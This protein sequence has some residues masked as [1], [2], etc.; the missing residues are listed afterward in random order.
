L[1]FG[2]HDVHIGLQGPDLAKLLWVDGYAEVSPAAD[3]VHH[4][5][6]PILDI[7]TAN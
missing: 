5:D 7:R 2:L 3:E 4:F 1:A 6:C